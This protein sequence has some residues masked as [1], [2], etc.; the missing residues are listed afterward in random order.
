MAAGRHL[1]LWD[2]RCGFCR[3]SAQWVGR[4]DTEGQF[5]ILPYQDAPAPPMTEALRRRCAHAAHVITTGGEVIGAGRAL[6]FI[7][8]ALGWPRLAW[9][10]S[11]PPLVWAIEVGYWIVARNRMIFSRFMFRNE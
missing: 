2:G 8:R 11:L 1:L 3:R 9:I 6:L 5:E 4:Q 10:L 7:I